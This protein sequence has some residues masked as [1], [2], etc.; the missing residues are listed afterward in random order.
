MTRLPSASAFRAAAAR[1]RQRE[2]LA[3][4]SALVANPHLPSHIARG[5]A[6][7]AALVGDLK[8]RGL[9]VEAFVGGAYA[10]PSLRAASSLL[11]AARGG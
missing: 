3:V 5:W 11:R 7:A 6:R 9:P 1:E 10:P 2:R 4:A 8:A